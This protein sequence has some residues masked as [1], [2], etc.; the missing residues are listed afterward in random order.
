MCGDSTSRYFPSLQNSSVSN[1]F[2]I[3]QEKLARKDL[4]S[5]YYVPRIIVRLYNLR[6][7]L[8]GWVRLTRCS[9]ST[10]Q[11]TTLGTSFFYRDHFVSSQKELSY[12]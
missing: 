9:R 7:V 4:N 1:P 12:L 5:Q 2:S 6:A 3:L 8:W 10:C 11:Q